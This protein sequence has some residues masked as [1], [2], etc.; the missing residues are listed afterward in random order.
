MKGDEDKKFMTEN[1]IR[2]SDGTETVVKYQKNDG[3]E[4]IEAEVAE[5]LEVTSPEELPDAE[6]PAIPEKRQKNP[7]MEEDGDKEVL[8]E[9]EE[10]A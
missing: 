7:G 6:M 3:A 5:A 8:E 9:V 1:I 2:F 10:E 4:E